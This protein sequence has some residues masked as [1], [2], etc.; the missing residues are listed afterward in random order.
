MPVASVNPP[1]SES[2][3]Y[4]R[5][6][7][8][9]SPINLRFLS[10]RARARRG[11]TRRSARMRAGPLYPSDGVTSAPV[12]PFPVSRSRFS[13]RDPGKKGL[14][15]GRRGGGDGKARVENVK[16]RRESPGGTAETKGWP[17]KTIFR[18]IVLPAGIVYG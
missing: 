8:A 18:I 17:V 16:G 9:M 13:Q 7:E 6:D 12:G 11:K 15:D 2:R 10:P 14:Y 1:R 3:R 4:P 5:I